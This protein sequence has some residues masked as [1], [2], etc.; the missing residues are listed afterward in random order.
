MLKISGI[1]IIT[2]TLSAFLKN[3]RSEIAQYLPQISALIIFFGSIGALVPIISFI[4]ELF[5]GAQSTSSISL[6]T[7]FLATGISII[8]KIICDLCKENGYDML[9]NAVEFAGNTEILLLC[10]PIIREL[11]KLTEK[12]LAL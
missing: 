1:A 5:N 8:C 10:V 6:S 12:T 9:K 4:K 2:I 3:Q 7:L 11:F